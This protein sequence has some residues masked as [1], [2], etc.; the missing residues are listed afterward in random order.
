MIEEAI[1]DYIVRNSRAALDSA[2]LTPDTDVIAEGLV[3]SLM[4]LQ[5]TDFIEDHFGVE[6]L[7]DDLTFENFG[8]IA[9]ITALIEDRSGKV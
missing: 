7:P 4:L 9:K 6:I 3:D 1:R 8:S 5:M 2:S